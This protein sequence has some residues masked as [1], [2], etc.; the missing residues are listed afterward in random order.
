[1][2]F[3]PIATSLKPK[4]DATGYTQHARNSL[5]P[6]D[7]SCH[8]Y[9]G[10]VV[11]IAIQAL[12]LRHHGII[13]C[14]HSQPSSK[15]SFPDFRVLEAENLAIK[16]GFHPPCQPFVFYGEAHLRPAISFGV[17]IQA[18]VLHEHR[19]FISQY[20]LWLIM[21]CVPFCTCHH[22]KVRH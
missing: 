20:L 1:M 5:Q 4:P 13:K 9:K 15:H 6:H 12:N 17:K 10:S 3:T 19:T 14:V 11:H 16:S 7:C 2:T 8:S 22:L 21:G 18:A